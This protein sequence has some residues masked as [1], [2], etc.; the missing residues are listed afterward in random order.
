[1][2]GKFEYTK[3]EGLPGGANEMQQFAKGVFSIEGYK[4]FSPDVNNPFNIIPSGDITMKDVD[5]PVHGVDNLGNSQIMYPGN[6]YKFPGSTVFETPLRDLDDYEEA[7]LT[8]AEI[9]DLRAQGYIVE[10]YQDGGE[11]D[12]K[13]T[14]EVNI[15][16]LSAYYNQYN[17]NNPYKDYLINEKYDYINKGNKGLQ[18]LF[19]VNEKNFPEKAEQRIR[20]QY[21]YD[22]NNYVIEQY[23]KENNID[24]TD[25]ESIMNNP[26]NAKVL[27][28]A[29]ANSKYAKYIEPSLWA[30]T[31]AGAV[32][33]ANALLD[34]PQG[35]Y[36]PTFTPDIKGLTPAE[37]AQYYYPESTLQKVGNVADALSFVDIPGAAMMKYLTDADQETTL[38]DALTG[39][40][41]PSTLNAAALPGIVAAPAGLYNAPDL[42]STSIRGIGK[43]GKYADDATQ[44]LGDLA[45]Y[46]KRESIDD[47]ITPRAYDKINPFAGSKLRKLDKKYFLEGRKARNKID[48]AVENITTNENLQREQR[49]KVQ[50]Y[51]SD[52]MNQNEIV[53]KYIENLSKASRYN[54]DYDKFLKRSVKN[55]DEQP[56]L[57]KNF[58][59]PSKNE[60]VFDDYATTP[61]I[62]E[63]AESLRTM[64]K[65]GETIIDFTTGE[66][67]IPNVEKPKSSVG[68]KLKLEEGVL[69]SEKTFDNDQNGNFV[70]NYKFDEGLSKLYTNNENFIKEQIPGFQ[71]LGSSQYHKFGIGHV[72]SDFDGI[73]KAEDWDKVKNNF[74]EVGNAKFGPKIELR[75]P[76]L[77]GN[78]VV[79]DEV[80]INIINTDPK[81][82]YAYGDL[83]KE[84]FRQFF[85]EEFYKASEKA[86]K[87]RKDSIVVNKTADEL[88]DAYDPEIKSILD[89]FEA[90]SGYGKA[91]H[92][93][94][95]DLILELGDTDKVLKAQ[96]LF[97]KVLMG[98]NA[99][100][101]KQF[102]L[103]VFDDVR[104][105]VQILEA[106]QNVKN[107]LYG[108]LSGDTYVPMLIAQD[109]KKMQLALNDFYINNSIFSR[110]I[111][112]FSDKID[113]YE[114]ILKAYEKW[115][116]EGGENMGIGLNSTK[117]GDPGQNFGDVFGN[118]QF[119]LYNQNNK[120]TP[121]EYI[122]SIVK[123]TSG[124][125]PV[126]DLDRT[127]INK[128][129]E[130][131]DIKIKEG[132]EIPTF[133]DLLD[134]RDY[135]VRSP[136]WNQ[137]KFNEETIKLRNFLYDIGKEFGMKAIARGS[138]SNSEYATIL[139]NID[140]SIDNLK[141]S[142]NPPSQKSSLERQRKLKEAYD[143]Y[144]EPNIAFPQTVED[145]K[146]VQGY[147]DGGIE[148]AKERRT[149][150]GDII[151]KMGDQQKRKS[152]DFRDRLVELKVEKKLVD[153]VAYN[154]LI[155]DQEQA[156]LILKEAKD[157]YEAIKKVIEG[158]EKRKNV[159]NKAK[160]NLVIGTAVA[161][162]FA[163]MLGA[164]LYND[165]DEDKLD[166]EWKRRKEKEYEEA[167]LTD[168]QIAELRA[169]GYQVEEYQDGGQ[170]DNRFK[171]R[172]MRK[173]PAF[174]NV[175]GQQGENLNI[176]KDPNFNASDYGYGNIEFI[177][178]GGTGTVNY[179][180][181]QY[182]SPTPDK[183]TVAYNPKGAAKG[184]I[185]LDMMH[186]MRDD[187]EYMKL[188]DNFSSAVREGRGG[189]MDF[190]Y[191]KDL[192]EG[193]A[194][195]GRDRWEEN[196]IDGI[197]RSELARKGVGRKVSDKSDYK[198]T[199]KYNSDAI[200]ESA[201]T[202]R[203]YLKQKQTGGQS[204][205]LTKYQTKGEVKHEWEDEDIKTFLE[206][207]TMVRNSP[208]LQG[209][210]KQKQEWEAANPPAPA[211]VVEE[212]TS[213]TPKV[214]MMPDNFQMNDTEGKYKDPKL[215]AAA[216]EAP[217]SELDNAITNRDV[218]SY[219]DILNPFKNPYM[220]EMLP[221]KEYYAPE[222]STPVDSSKTV[223]EQQAVEEP[224]GTL[225]GGFDG[226]EFTD[227]AVPQKD[228][229]NIDLN[230]EEDEFEFKPFYLPGYR[231]SD[232]IY[233][234]H[235]QE[236]YDQNEKADAKMQELYYTI[237]NPNASK[238]DKESA[239]KQFDELKDLIDANIG[240]INRIKK[241]QAGPLDV[242][243]Q[244]ETPSWLSKGLQKI[245]FSDDY[246][247]EAPAGEK[248]Y[249]DYETKAKRDYEQE[250]VTKSYESLNTP[251]ESGQWYRWK[252]RVNA[253]NDDPVTVKL[254]GNRGERDKKDPNIKGLGAMMHFL[255]QSPLTGSAH[256][257]MKN[258][259]KRLGEDQY[260]GYLENV[261]GDTY[262]LMYKK[263]GELS[264]D[265]LNPK[266]TFYL[267]TED[268]DNINF[269][270]KRVKDDNF[271]GHTYWT[272]K[273]NGEAT[274]PISIGHN[275]NDYNYSS[276]NAVVF[277]FDYKGQRR[278]IQFAGS[279]NAIRK[280]GERIKKDYKLD[281]NSLTIGIADAGSYASAVKADK[282]GKVNNKLLNSKD[283]GYW[284]LNNYTGA[285]MVLQN[286][287]KTGGQYIEAELTPEEI[288][289]YLSQ[290]Y[291]IDE[292]E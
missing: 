134:M 85:P 278:Y 155:N 31:K 88:L 233:N 110:R 161:S 70:E 272:R 213:P 180:D 206:D 100:L 204:N 200:R 215:Y 186:G 26:A 127:S 271:S 280:E 106:M 12:P 231:F 247:L 47:V 78:P 76:N 42:L 163:L 225:D 235:A 29:M 18:S 276:G 282:Q 244:E 189:D 154:K 118:R 248:L 150:L 79:A 191:N 259:Y 36:G 28:K 287:F 128:I 151:A 173:Y 7:E 77:K 156:R 58:S 265:E 177:F 34:G 24:L 245:G 22:R 253:S 113:S 108:I 84:L 67:Y 153:D 201:N 130:K 11:P 38:S 145:F 175:Y 20:D 207:P 221:N 43:V 94:K 17:D 258:F 188:L 55:L 162:P 250:L 210:L 124:K 159:L 97:A 236:Y 33:A 54:K 268:F 98:E 172:L 4:R 49:N 10:E 277:I 224:Q 230:F 170:S 181:Y 148:L 192:E 264:K 83:A 165:V 44:Y 223:E 275:D 211:P 91:K 87:K 119:K 288:N 139:G 60:I 71:P 193:F 45:T 135:I 53:N 114:D 104:T 274:I 107:D 218:R 195:D 234:Q 228:N 158:L 178:P 23:A 65:K 96:K 281:P 238:K 152:Y 95:T 263:A 239:Q 261:G 196:Y 90:G 285:G 291:Q 174:Q 266:N 185:F 86:I 146:K 187:S 138:F 115:I 141:L 48:D 182:T 68:Q 9:A 75:N 112:R 101:G 69:K 267:R 51:V 147:I 166:A 216:P 222:K 63:A 57:Y 92:I 73:I 202:I 40:Y 140:E 219:S 262:K 241:V 176:Y 292:L 121:L 13:T 270:G 19:N 149:K 229:M 46:L 102:P 30:R 257:S 243:I 194:R 82:G 199:R 144:K 72:T 129:A 56:W 205:E 212:E 242:F 15:T 66:K 109:P 284:N 160:K 122:E 8:E 198:L 169:K 168:E 290:G 203:K 220:K 190:F 125:R 256:P 237:T 209:I 137:T 103:E 251:G 255:D 289:W 123:Q 35:V 105:N 64:P 273:D 81:T 5:F 254:Y 14:R 232:N 52:E 167:E 279:P 59:S 93:A 39:T 227:P 116:A 3:R 246:S 1:M 133:G 131:H 80:D 249:E 226:F 171:Q 61:T 286:D 142:I 89:A 197:L 179:G 164:N 6:D 240:E 111:N 132:V 184:D 252:Y 269:D 217:T 126:T 136:D 157:E 214:K 117:L 37:E 50:Y 32:S 143:S 2:K 25:R 120:E 62:Y 283:Y 41:T 21:E 99:D 74:T 27:S 208:W 183:Y 16:P 260:I